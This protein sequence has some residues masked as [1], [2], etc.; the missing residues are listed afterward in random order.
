MD[1]VN[2]DRTQGQLHVTGTI[3]GLRGLDA[4]CDLSPAFDEFIALQHHGSGDGG[5]ECIA[6]T[7]RSGREWVLKLHGKESSGSED[8]RPR[9][10]PE[11][12]TGSQFWVGRDCGV[13]GLAGRGWLNV[14]MEGELLFSAHRSAG[15]GWVRRLGAIASL[16]EA[17]SKAKRN[18]GG[19][20]ACISKPSH[21]MHGRPVFYF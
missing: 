1:A 20:V 13:D 19:A 14:G 3:V 11:G 6:G 15:I 2:R 17:Q 4:S 12:K 9:R 21:S 5:G 18:P 8:S 16:A 10:S 7:N